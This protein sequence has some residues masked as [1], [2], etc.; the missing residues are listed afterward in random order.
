M[1]S[2]TIGLRAG[3]PPPHSLALV[4]ALALHDAVLE[5][6][7]PSAVRIKW[8]N[9]LM[10]ND[11]KLAG[12]LLE[13]SGDHAVLGMGVNIVQAPQIAGRKTVSL[14]AIG[15]SAARDQLAKALARHWS[16]ALNDWRDGGWPDAILARWHAA[17]HPPGTPL[18]LTEGEH[19]G[20]TGKFD[21]LERDGA[22]ALKLDD[23]RRIIVHAGD[24]ML[25]GNMQEGMGH[26]AGH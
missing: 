2:V 24:V 19:R 1:G 25:A 11:A 14:A 22:L 18:T 10:V 23:G 15:C 4:A 7:A 17:A 6:G 9:D 16:Q 3:D 12:I 13:R 5:M 8:P 20:L 26:A 21:G